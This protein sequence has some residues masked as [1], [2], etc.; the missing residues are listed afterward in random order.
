MSID[1]RSQAADGVMEVREDGRYV[2]RFE[3]RLPHPPDRVWPALTE[4]DQ[5][6]Q[7]FP[8]DIEGKR[9]P[10]AKIRFVFR[11]D[12]PSAEELPELL[13]HDP[14][15][16]DGEITDFEPPR[17]LAYTWGEEFLSWELRPDPDGCLLVFTTTFDERGGNIPHPEGP[18]KKGARDAAGWHAC[19][20]ALEALVDGRPPAGDPSTDDAWR[21]LYESYVKAFD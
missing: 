19:L 16:L 15:T 3:R 10:G 9:R 4:P 12:A 8:A 11:D 13:E 17:L 18:R 21:P 14:E 20:D 2:L 7:W 5:L 1:S 6:R